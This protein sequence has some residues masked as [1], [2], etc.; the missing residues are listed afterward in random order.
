M[1]LLSLWIHLSLLTLSSA[2]TTL[3]AA[4]P[5]DDAWT[6]H[7]NITVTWA[8]VPPGATNTSDWIG[9]FLLNYN[10]TYIKFYDITPDKSINGSAQF[11]LLNGRHP[12]HFKLMR[13]NEVLTT[14]NV[15]Y[16]NTTLPTQGHLSFVPEG[17]GH[18]NSMAISWT[19]ATPATPGVVQYGLSKSDLN[20][21]AMSSVD[22]YSADDFTTCMGIPSIPPRVVPFQNLSSRSLRCGF[23]CY[24]DPTSSEMFLHPGY[25]HTATM[26]RLQQ[27]KR[28]YYT[29]GSSTNIAARSP[30][31]SFVAPREEEIPSSTFTFIV[32]G[33]MGIGGI[34][35]GEAGGATDNDPYHVHPGFP[36]GIDNGADWVVRQ[37]IL[38]DSLTKNDEFILVNG[39]IS[40]ARGWPWIWEV[41][42]DLVQP[43]TTMMPMMVSVGNHEVDSHENP[44][45]ATDGGDSGGECGVVA[46]KRFSAHLE[47]PQK[48]YYSFTHGSIHVVV[49][50]TEHPI[51]EQVAFFKQDVKSLNR[52]K[53]PW[54][55]V[56][57]HR[58]IFISEATPA[59]LQK[60]LSTT[61]HPLFAE[62]GVDFVYTGHAHY[63]E[64]LCAVEMDPHNFTNTSCSKKRDRPVYIVD[65][66]A[67][68][69]PDMK[70]PESKLTKYKEFGKWGYSR[71]FVSENS[72]EM[73]HYAA[74]IG[75]DGSSVVLPYQMTDSVTLPRRK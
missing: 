20:A 3:L 57:L 19:T 26:V 23:Q 5:T 24:D 33:D 34:H 4:G 44:F 8:N 65:G 25:L 40:Y 2:Q 59:G 71:L 62:S 9:A 69:E 14:S 70:S 37:G 66:T 45:E 12:Y 10:S 32:T 27:G 73:R 11:Q 58:P 7:A 38:A 61:W 31:Y 36:Q 21:T 64:R 74:K 17:V 75:V 22:T 15:L 50:S 52:D 18:S 63:Y 43:L 67:G 56:S 6:S 16:P 42:F 39:D 13:N 53:V 54:L 72:L 41:F 1:E 29:F 68:A 48:M 47:S 49:L 46:A 35:E 51:A 28:Y 55:L 30:V 60:I